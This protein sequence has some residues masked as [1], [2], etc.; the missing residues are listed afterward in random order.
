[1]AAHAKAPSQDNAEY[2][3]SQIKE[4]ENRSGKRRIN[5]FIALRGIGE[6]FHAGNLMMLDEVAARGQ[7]P[8]EI[9]IGNGVQAREKRIAEGQSN[10]ANAKPIRKALGLRAHDYL[11][12]LTRTGRTMRK[13]PGAT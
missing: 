6:K 8:A 5:P 3:P 11:F 13:A 12:C 10:Q 2:P 7:L 1:M 4:I 9:Q